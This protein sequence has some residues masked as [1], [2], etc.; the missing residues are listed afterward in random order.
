MSAPSD[1][2]PRSSSQS[3]LLAALIALSVIN[4][5]LSVAAFKGGMDVSESTLALWY[6]V[7]SIV[8]AVWLRNDIRQHPVEGGEYPPFL[9][10]LIWIVLLPYH[11]VRT[12]G[13][14]GLML[15]VSFFAAYLAPYFAQLVVWA[16]QSR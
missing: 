12:R 14:E 4:T 7:F 15:S 11:L 5:L 10:F 9:I 13:V 1:T 8:V 6:F 2:P 3:W 16:K